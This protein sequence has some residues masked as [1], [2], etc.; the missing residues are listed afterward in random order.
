MTKPLICLSMILGN[1]E[2]VIE[3]FL[4]SIEPAVDFAVFVQAIGTQ[5][6][7][8]TMEIIGRVCEELDLPYV[9][10]IYFNKKPWPHVDNFAKARQKAWEIACGTKADYLMW[11]DADDLLKKGAAEALRAAAQSGEKDVYMAPY[12]VRGDKQISWRE[13]LIKNSGFSHWIKPIHE[14]LSFT[15]DV[16]IKS[17]HEAVFIH[18]PLAGRKNSA[19]RN[20]RI[21]EVEVQEGGSN[22]FF[23]AQEAASLGDRDTYLRCAKAALAHPCT[24]ILDKYEIHL[25]LAQSEPVCE[26]AKSHA[27]RAYDLMPDR[28]EALALLV[29]YALIDGRNEEAFH[30][31]KN[32]MGLPKPRLGYYSLNHEWYDWKGFYLFTQTL[33]AIGKPEE[34]LEL[35][36]EQFNKNGA[37]FSICHP[38]YLR[39]HQALAI[40]DLYLSRARNPMAVEYIFGIHHDDKE[41]L[42]LLSGFR[43]TIT[44]REGCCPNTLEPLRASKGKFVM[45]IADDL[46]PPD[47][48][49]ELIANSI[50]TME[51]PH[52]LNFADGLRSLGQGGEHLCHAF[53]TRPWLEEMLKDPWPG[54]GIY[55]DNEF[56]HRANK[57]GVIIDAPNIIFE[58]KH[59]S[60]GKSPNDA[61]YQD[62]NKPTNYTEGKRLFEE[63]N[64]DYAVHTLDSR[65]KELMAKR[66]GEMLSF[67]QIGAH[68]GLSSDPLRPYILKHR[69]TGILVE[70]QPEL[71]KRLVENYEGNMRLTFE[72]GAIGNENGKVKLYRF[73]AGQNLPDHATM[74][75]SFRA[76]ALIYNGHGYKGEIEEIEVPCV[77]FQT[78]LESHGIKDLDV[79]QIDTEGFDYEILKMMATSELRPA[80]IHYEH[81]MLHGHGKE[82]CEKMLRELGYTLTLLGIDTVAF[83]EEL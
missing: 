20:F 83:K 78:L 6:P 33:R 15:R 8:R 9:R 58:H 54:T 47:G 77:T 18:A 13:R 24:A 30:L 16:Q 60:T 80:L 29:C 4:R 69:W 48:W 67:I 68:D 37:V 45:V 61:T 76:D 7:D 5:V 64:P 62:Q 10:Q 44:D 2:A 41:S 40:R 46:F 52:V 55:S 38:T 66:G 19:E 42:A 65:I 75:T 63:R 1:E 27:S 49:D 56:T 39:P 57:A 50:P 25:M 22:L 26:I 11:A 14:T 79:L 31:A 51:E 73:K 53:M 21:L 23:L 43:H 71:F 59:F 3:R 17:L 74:L 32:M 12:H 36:R 34:A 72:N 81:G 35:E 70:P 28:R 82:A